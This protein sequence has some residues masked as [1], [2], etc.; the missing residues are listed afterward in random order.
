VCIEIYGE[1]KLRASRRQAIRDEALR[2]VCVVAAEQE[3][4]D[5]GTA[6][7]VDRFF[8]RR[9]RSAPAL[10]AAA[11][12]SPSACA[13]DCAVRPLLPIILITGYAEARLAADLPG[14]VQLLR[15]PFRVCELLARVASAVAAADAAGAKRSNIL[16]CGR[17]KN[18]GSSS[19][20]PR[21]RMRPGPGAGTCPYQPVPLSGFLKPRTMAAPPRP[22]L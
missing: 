15:K 10:G 20:A 5:E 14:D 13:R 1:V 9:R 2:L 18:R 12:R 6:P 7:A 11:T 19:K 3:R 8:P 4:I 21:R 16:R 17:C 22:S